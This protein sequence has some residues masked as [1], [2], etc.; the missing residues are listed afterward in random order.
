MERITDTHIYFW[1][2]EL[3]NWYNC[4][5]NYK[6]HK[7]KNSEQAFMW[8]KAM[9]FWDN[10]TAQKILN[11]PNPKKNKLLGRQ[12]KNFKENE[13]SKISYDIMVNI[14]Y[15][16][17]S[18]N[19]KLKKLLLSTGSKI[20]VE[21]SPFDVIWGIGLHWEDDLV[22]NESNWR[23]QNLLGKVLMEVRKRIF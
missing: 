7:F 12:V 1:G 22:L 8:E 13:W 2:S 6:G 14:N 21:A 17:W 20:L 19:T 5:F 23:G 15:C 9:Y 10:E 18:S 16:K 4:T 11:E 3:S